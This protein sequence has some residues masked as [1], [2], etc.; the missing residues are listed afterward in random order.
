MKKTKTKL[1]K[2]KSIK[3]KITHYD[4]YEIKSQ[5]LSHK[6]ELHW[7]LFSSKLILH[8]PHIENAIVDI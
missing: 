3:V 4:N 1:D 8:Q 6:Y 2:K 5:H 7:E